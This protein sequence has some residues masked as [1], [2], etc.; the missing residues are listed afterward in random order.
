MNFMNRAWLYIV[1]KRGKS[2]PIVL[3]VLL[4]VGTQFFFG[5][6]ILQEG[7]VLFYGLVT[8]LLFCAIYLTYFGA[9]M[10]LF[11]RVILRPEMH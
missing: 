11:K 9:T 8:I 4:I 10:S 3:T 1:R 2:F 6:A 7:L 5:E